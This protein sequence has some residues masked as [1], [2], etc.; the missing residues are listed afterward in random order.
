MSNVVMDW[1][2]IKNKKLQKYH[3]VSFYVRKSLL[4][5]CMAFVEE[6]IWLYC[7]GRWDIRQI[8]FQNSARPPI[9]YEN[10]RRGSRRVWYFNSCWKIWSWGTRMAGYL[11]MWKKTTPF[12]STGTIN[13]DI[14]VKECLTKRLKPFLKNHKRSSFFWSDLATA[15]YSDWT[16]EWLEENKINV[17]QKNMNPPNCHKLRPIERYWARIKSTLRKTGKTAQDVQRFKRLWN[18]AAKEVTEDGVQNL[19]CNIKPKIRKF[20]RGEQIF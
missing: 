3:P 12:F 15:H 10:D 7:D 13:T 8:W 20:F 1:R 19:M 17:C 18:A 4:E 9:L 6:K 14:Y 11:S 5:D 16:L 2:A